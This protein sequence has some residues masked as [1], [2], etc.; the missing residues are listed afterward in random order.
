MSPKA[1]LLTEQRRRNLLD[2]VDQQGQV[3]VADMVKCFAISAVTVRSDL[4]ALASLGAV[5]RSHG[6]AVRRLEATQDYPLR[7]KETLHHEEKGR[8]GRATAEM[9]QPG[10]TTM[11]GSSTPAAER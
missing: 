11:L 9:V 4:D 7:T 3:T 10:K 8:R 6:G 1:R 2:L 5:V